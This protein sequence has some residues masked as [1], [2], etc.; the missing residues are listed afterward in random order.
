MQLNLHPRMVEG[1]IP[2]RLAQRKMKIGLKQARTIPCYIVVYCSKTCK[3]RKVAMK[4]DR[5]FH[6]LYLLLE[7]G[8]VCAPELA[9][10][11]EVSVRTV[12]RDVEA[13]SMVTEPSSG[14]YTPHTKRRK[15]DLPAP[16]APT[17]P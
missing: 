16:F 5:L 11:L 8:T 7:K 14:R 1:I 4:N 2:S 12:Y 3:R 9:A 6:L 17:R 15:V 10:L 13:L